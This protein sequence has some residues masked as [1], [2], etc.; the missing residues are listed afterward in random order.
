M[1][2]FSLDLAQRVTRK[3]TPHQGVDEL[4]S[5]KVGSSNLKR[6]NKKDLSNS[7][8]VLVSI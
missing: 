7:D 4:F 1:I 5:G 3:I 6:E 8:L 2:K